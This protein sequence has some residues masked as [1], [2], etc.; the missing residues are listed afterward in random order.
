MFLTAGPI[1]LA[2]Q[3]QIYR[4]TTAAAVMCALPE[5]R[6]PCLP[7]RPKL[8]DVYSETKFVLYLD[9]RGK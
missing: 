3:V 5:R 7:L 2:G 6:P 1:T 4:S 9:G 8:N